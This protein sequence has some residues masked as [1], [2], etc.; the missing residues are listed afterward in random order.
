VDQ[1]LRVSSCEEERKAALSKGKNE[2]GVM[3]KRWPAVELDSGA[4]GTTA[5]GREV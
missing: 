2:R 5:V 3:P 4:R 1:S